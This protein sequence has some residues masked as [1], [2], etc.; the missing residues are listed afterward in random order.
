MNEIKEE[1]KYEEC[2][3]V[4]L[5]SLF[6]K[7]SKSLPYVYMRWWSMGA[8]CHRDMQTFMI[9]YFYFLEFSLAA[10]FFFYIFFFSYTQS[11]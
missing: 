8:N 6:P 7:A 5:I 2:G 9:E 1:N 10:C 3:V 11:N 4:T